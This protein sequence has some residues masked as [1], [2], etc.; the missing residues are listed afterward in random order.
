M[1]LNIQDKKLIIVEIK[2]AAENALSAVIA[3]I[4]G[5]NVEKMTELRKSCRKSDV[6]IRV[7]RN[8]LINRAFKGT[9]YEILKNAFTG[10]TL[11]A[12]SNKH[13]GAA[14]RLFKE[15]AKTH[16]SFKIKAAAFNGKL[17]NAEDIDLLASIPTYKEA[18]M[19]LILTIQEASTKKL[20]RTLT[21][22]RDQKKI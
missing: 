21:A 9:F 6:Y 19:Q 12:F 14:A 22:I 15:F 1:A 3:D 11:I 20:L 10:S 4:R 7:V 17:I 2:K 5:I 8:T 16:Q 13:P 18:I